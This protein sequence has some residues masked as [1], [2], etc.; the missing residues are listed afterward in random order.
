MSKLV[1][2]AEV[3]VMDMVGESHSVNSKPWA[4]SS[5]DSAVAAGKSLLLGACGGNSTVDC[6]HC[7]EACSHPPPRESPSVPTDS[8]SATAAGDADEVGLGTSNMAGLG[9]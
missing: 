9:S 8:E 1:P 2:L 6:K 5:S 7:R 3:S 4:S